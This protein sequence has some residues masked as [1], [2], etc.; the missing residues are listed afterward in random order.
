MARKNVPR[1][2]LIH[3]HQNTVLQ[4]QFFYLAFAF[5]SNVQYFLQKRKTLYYKGAHT[6]FLPFVHNRCPHTCDIRS[7]R[8]RSQPDN[9]HTVA[10]ALVE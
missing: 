8:A 1:M 2:T 3:C 10:A 7:P 5:F 6:F 4:L 9:R